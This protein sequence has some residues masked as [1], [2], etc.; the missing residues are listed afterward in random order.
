MAITLDGTAGITT[1]DL[2]DTS[3]TA[4]RVVYAGTS[5]N[6]TGASTLTFDGTTL[7]SSISSAAAGLSLDSSSAGKANTVYR[8]AGTQKAIV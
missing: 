6:L 1:P 7:S 4:T 8:S 2:T 5:G 3:L